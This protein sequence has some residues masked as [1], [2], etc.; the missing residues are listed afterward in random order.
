MT[1]SVGVVAV[2]LVIFSILMWR[3]H[4][5]LHCVRS[6]ERLADSSNSFLIMF[7]YMDLK[8]ATRNFRSKLGSGGFSTVF[9]G[10]LIDGTVVAV[11]KMEGSRQDEKQFRAE[12]SSLGI[13]QHANLTR[14]R[15]FCAEG[16]RRFLIYD[17]MPNGSL[18]SLVFT[19]NS[20]SKQKILDWKKRFEIAL[21]T[22]RGLLY[23]HEECRDCIIHCDMKAENILLD[24]NFS[25]KLADFGFARLLG[26]NFSCVLT[27]TRG[28]RGYLAP[29]WISDLTITPKVDVYSF[30]MTL[31]EIISGRRNPDLSVQDSSQYYFPSWAATQIY[32][33][34]TINIVDKGIAE[35]RD[36]EEVRRASIVGLLC[37]EKDEELRPS[38]GQVVLM[39][40]G[41]IQ[42]QITQTK[43]FALMDKQA[44]RSDTH[45]GSDN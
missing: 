9:K 10:Y 40:E 12:V 3:R 28:T 43:C 35:E 16:S 13:I 11:K 17:Y 20:K 45:S 34:N 6:M 19:S 44:D 31:L 39:L 30:G 33:G 42:P 15:G 23:L 37:I 21:G 1:F 29:E 18:N 32:I 22:A 7:S 2:A 4:R 26:R 8:I 36:L 38:M 27:T 14:L 5:Q 24:N 25:P 41:K